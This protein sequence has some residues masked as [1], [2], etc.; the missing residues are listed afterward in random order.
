VLVKAEG[1]YA[2]VVDA[3]RAE[4]KLI[5]EKKE[6]EEQQKRDAEKEVADMEPEKLF[7]EVVATKVAEQVAKS[8][9]QPGPAQTPVKVEIVDEES[10]GRSKVTDFIAALSKN[11]ATP[12]VSSGAKQTK[13]PSTKGGKGRGGGGGKSSSGKGTQQ[14][15]WQT[16]QRQPQ[17]PLG[18]GHAAQQWNPRSTFKQYFGA[19]LA[20]KAKGKGAD[21]AAA[22]QPGKGSGGKKSSKGHAPGRGRR[23]PWDR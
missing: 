11:G 18:K 6:K 17:Q 20:G 10:E 2:K 22:S 7:E 15:R 21:S 3:I 8:L 1:Y 4:R 14:W 12:G 13:P 19:K 16:P 5:K 23:M 9:R